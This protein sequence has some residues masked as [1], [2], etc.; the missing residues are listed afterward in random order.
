MDAKPLETLNHLIHRE[1]EERARAAGAACDRSRR[2][3]VALAGLFRD[4]IEARRDAV[5]AVTR[6]TRTADR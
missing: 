1:G 5:V 2:A 6:A 4:R 3:H